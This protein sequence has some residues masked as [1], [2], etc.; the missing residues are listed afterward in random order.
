MQHQSLNVID[1]IFIVVKIKA[2]NKVIFQVHC[3][4]MSMTVLWLYKYIFFLNSGL[5]DLLD[6]SCF[7]LHKAASYIHDHNIETYQG[8]L[9]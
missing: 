9:F 7:S 1:F 3:N 5:F 6:V 8:S 2:L 4:S